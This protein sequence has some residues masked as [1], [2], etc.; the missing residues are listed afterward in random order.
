M[1]GLASS[2]FCV[3]RYALFALAAHERSKFLDVTEYVLMAAY[4]CGVVVIAGLLWMGPRTVCAQQSSSGALTY[5]QMMAQQQQA[6]ARTDAAAAKH[7]KKKQQAGDEAAAPLAA[8]PAA[9]PTAAPAV[10]AAAP[11]PAVDGT[12]AAAAPAAA[13][14][15]E[16]TTAATDASATPA[17]AGDT[18]VAATTDGAAAAPAP[19]DVPPAATAATSLKPVKI[20]NGKHGP[21]PK[22][23]KPPKLVPVDIVHGELTVDGLIAKAGLNFQ[24]ID[25]RYFYIWVPGLGTAVVS[26]QPFAGSTLEL[27]A[28]DG[29]TL[30]VLVDNHKLQLTCDRPMLVGKS[31]SKKKEKALT[32]YVA[33]DRNWQ[34]PSNYPEFGYG[35]LPKAPYSWPGT[36][37]DLTPA[38]KAPPL[39]DNLKQHPESVK[40]CGKDGDPSSCRQVSVPLVLG[41]NS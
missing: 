40:M 22:K 18:A 41:K 35:D 20:Q 5:D 24:I 37:A 21:K 32:M 10:T 12:T 26:N 33:L 2:S 7:S 28:L 11:S 17:A 31:K 29:N 30:T 6:K 16:A 27:D 25:I 38:G 3:G 39:P 14:A 8:A 15:A 9:A 1:I 36:L 13:P 23:E 4:R 19:T 34:K